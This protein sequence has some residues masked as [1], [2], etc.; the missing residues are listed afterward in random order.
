MNILV[1]GFNL[2]ESDRELIVKIVSVC[3]LN[4]HQVDIKDIKTTAIEFTDIDFLI[5]LGERT[6]RSLIPMAKERG[7]LHLSLPTIKNLYPIEYGG[8]IEDRVRTFKELSNLSEALKTGQ[9]QVVADRKILTSMKPPA[10]IGDLSIAAIQAL[11]KVIREVG[12][13]SWTCT[14]KDGKVVGITTDTK[15]PEPDGVDFCI[16]F[17][18]LLAMRAAVD[19]FQTD[20]IKFVSTNKLPTNKNC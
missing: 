14:T 11:E 12:R 10:A 19:I 2:N 1:V 9:L 6:A 17:A 4:M 18:E 20:G 16:T 15:Q 13:T 3:K 8:I 7:L 5:I